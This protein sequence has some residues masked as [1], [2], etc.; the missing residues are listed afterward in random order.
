MTNDKLPQK[1]DIRFD[2]KAEFSRGRR[3]KIL[4]RITYI[5]KPGECGIPKREFT[6]ENAAESS[7]NMVGHKV[8]KYI[9]KVIEKIAP[10]II[11]MFLC[12]LLWSEKEVKHLTTNLPSRGRDLI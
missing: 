11:I 9:P 2:L 12:I 7:Q 3:V 1:A 5:G 8:K 10:Q 6:A 4:P